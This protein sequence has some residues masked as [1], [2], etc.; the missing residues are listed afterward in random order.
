MEPFKNIYNKKSLKE[1]SRTIEKFSKKKFNRSQFLK[2]VN[3]ELESLEMKDRV[4]LISKKLNEHLET[5]YKASVKIL[6]QSLAPEDQEEGI[7]G[8]IAWPLLQFV[9]DYGLHDFQT[10]FSAMKEMTKRFSAEFAIRPFLIK[11]D[12]KV[13]KILEKWKSDKNKHVRRLCSEGI[14]PNLPW[15]LKVQGIN[16]D[17]QRNLKLIDSLKD[18]P[19]EYVRRSVANHLNDIS[20]LDID[21]ML[22]TAT[23]WSKSDCSEERAWII[24]HASRS[25]LKQGHPSA[26]KLHGYNPKIKTSLSKIKLDTKSVIEGSSFTLSFKIKNQGKRKEKLLLEYVIHYLKKDG[27]YS[28][29]PFRLKDGSLGSLETLEIEKKIPFKKVTTRAHYPG[30]HHLSVQVNGQ[31]EQKVSFQLS[32]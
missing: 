14:R 25:L 26:L 8:F 31:E 18:D 11:D 4:R 20:R 19:E 1:F 22:K 7:T 32:L 5:D 2:E 29:K 27:S 30:L 28:K 9:E 12:K 15:G 17:L 6:L 3:T 13:F 23:Q 10:S 21:L 16:D 24:R